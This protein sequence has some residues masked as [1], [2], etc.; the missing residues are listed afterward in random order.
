M[1]YFL[2]LMQLFYDIP[3]L[4]VLKHMP[5]RERGFPKLFSEKMSHMWITSLCSS[6]S[7][8]SPIFFF[9]FYFILFSFILFYFILIYFFFFFSF[10]F[11]FC[12]CLVYYLISPMFS[13]H[14]P[15]F[16]WCQP[17]LPAAESRLTIIV[18]IETAASQHKKSAMVW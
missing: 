13:C 5:W 3:F 11:F 4:H 14:P 2:D 7:T 1:I 8:S 18:C 9:F 15:L 16:S 17:E 12:C 6:S 10:F